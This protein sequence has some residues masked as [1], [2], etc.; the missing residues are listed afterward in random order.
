MFNL[1][2]TPRA[3][4]CQKGSRKGPL[5][6]LGRILHHATEHTDDETRTVPLES[7]RR[8]S[9]EKSRAREHAR[10]RMMLEQD[11]FALFEKTKSAAFVVTQQGEICSWNAAAEEV[12]GFRKSDAMHK[13]CYELLR[14]RD[15]LG[16]LACTEN[17]QVRECAAKHAEIPNF[18]LE[19]KD[20][21]GKRIWVSLSTLVYE[22]TLNG[23]QLIVHIANDITERKQSERTLDKMVQVAKHIMPMLTKSE[24]AIPA[25]S[26]SEREAEILQLFAEGKNS[27]ATAQ[28]IGITLQTLRN[29]LHH[30]N[31]KLGTHNRLEA[32]M[33]AVHHKLF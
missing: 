2:Q 16:T 21:S 22:N 11:L 31:Q 17:C 10:P 23:R 13:A 5:T 18:D 19:V 29:H 33:H 4:V 24:T 26:L 27:S 7:V 15:S 1:E 32:V 3:G 28:Q 6:V 30:V 25:S 14:G 9:S 20:L 12:F 8:S